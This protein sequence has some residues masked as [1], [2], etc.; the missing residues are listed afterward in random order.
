MARVKSASRP[1]RPLVLGDAAFGGDADAAGNLRPAG[2]ARLEHRVQPLLANANSSIAR[3][4]S[5]REASRNSSSS[6]IGSK[7]SNSSW[8]APIGAP[9]E[10]GRRAPWPAPVRAAPP[11]AACDILVVKRETGSG[12]R[13]LSNHGSLLATVKEEARAY[14]C[15]VSEH[16]GKGSLRSQL[17]AFAG[18][19]AVVAVHGA[20]LANLIVMPPGG[21]VIEIM[22]M[23]PDVNACYMDLAVKLR[24]R[25]PVL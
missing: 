15:S 20:G 9:R 12:T 11:P 23:R 24:L 2:A 22:P 25:S 3:E 6:S 8:A 16:N 1:W 18:A 13:S 10:A 19:S 17:L 4:S 7:T 21:L 14:G 5:A